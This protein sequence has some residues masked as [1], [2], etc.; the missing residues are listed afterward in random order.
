ME[1]FRKIAALNP[2]VDFRVI[3]N[4]Q[5]IYDLLSE[6]GCFT[7]ADRTVKQEQPVQPVEQNARKLSFDDVEK[8][9]TR[10]VILLGDGD[11]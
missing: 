5:I 8:I 3:S 6:L 11:D 4:L 10:T 2:T 7:D 9:Q 1:K